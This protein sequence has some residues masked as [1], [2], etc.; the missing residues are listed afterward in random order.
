MKILEFVIAVSAIILQ[1]VDAETTE[2]TNSIAPISL[3]SR[4]LLSQEMTGC[5]ISNA[6]SLGFF[7]T[8]VNSN[9]S[10]VY[11]T[12]FY[13]KPEVSGIYVF[14]FSSTDYEPELLVGSFG[15]DCCSMKDGQGLGDSYSSAD[16]KEF[17]LEAGNF[18]VPVVHLL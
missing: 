13:F 11:T 10:G 12:K 7:K 3:K 4:G 2:T 15:F 18:Q 14:S 17:Y 1:F 16:S 8:K 6:A 5:E 9:A